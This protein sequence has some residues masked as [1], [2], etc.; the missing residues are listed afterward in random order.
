[1]P[2]GLGCG[3]GPAVA[4]PVPSGRVVPGCPGGGLSV[5]GIAT[6]GAR[7]AGGAAV[8]TGSGSA[9]SGHGRRAG[10]DAATVGVPPGVGVR[11]GHGVCGTVSA[12]GL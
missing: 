4:V 7:A 2:D 11:A 3:G 8:R 5:W 6:S 12:T 10:R 1:M 9:G